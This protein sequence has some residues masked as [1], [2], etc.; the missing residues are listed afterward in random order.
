M[1]LGC[2]GALRQAHRRH[3]V[4]AVHIMD[5]FERELPALGRLVLEDAETG[6][7][8]EVNTSVPRLR[9]AFRERQEKAQAELAKMFRSANIDAIQL[10][11]GQPYGAALGK[12]F[13]NREK[14]RLRG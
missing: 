14:R 10:L 12:F 11:T 4:V 5:R 9:S 6:K 13:E 2:Y 1:S 7:I 3:D 8:I